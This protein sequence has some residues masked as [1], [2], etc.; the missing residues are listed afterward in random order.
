MKQTQDYL[1][2]I[3]GKTIFF[4]LTQTYIFFPLIFSESEWKAGREGE[5]EMCS[6]TWPA[7]GSNPQ[8]RY[9][10]LGME[11]PHSGAQSSALAKELYY[12]NK[13]FGEHC[14]ESL[15]LL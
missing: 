12:T 7:R 14:N 13:G 3:Y 5:R 10:S 6:L 9:M 4:N 2:V 15:R 11:P 8:S 1:K